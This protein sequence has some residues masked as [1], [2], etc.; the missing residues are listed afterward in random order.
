MRRSEPETN[1]PLPLIGITVVDLTHI[2]N[3]PYATF[4]MAMAGATVIK[5]EP[6]WGEHLRQRAE[7]ATA[8]VPFAMLNANKRAVTLDFTTERG[9]G[10]L[11]EMVRR[12]D[13]FVENFA[14]GVLDRH[15][16]GYRTLAQLFPT[17]IY[18]SSTGYGLSGP[19]RDYPAMDLTVQAMCGVLATTGDA[20]SGPTK[21]GPAV[22][23]FLA[24]V[25]LY[26]AIATALF[27]RERT[28]RGRL[29]EVSMQ[30][31]TY[32][33]LSSSIGLYF[34]DQ[35]HPLPRTGNHHSGLAEAPYGVYPARDG[36]IAIVGNHDRHFQ[37]IL[38]LMGRE[39]LTHD[40]RFHGLK[41]RAEHMDEVDDLVA[42]W[43]ATLD[44]AELAR[45]L[46]SQRVPCAPVREISEVVRDAHMHERG[47][48]EWIDHPSMGRIVVQRSPMRYQGSALTPLEP[49][50]TLGEHN[51]EVYADWLGF[52]DAELE[53]F[54]R[55]GII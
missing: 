5:V 26:G 20:E 47:A 33:S 27:E 7:L 42:D 14:P 36:Y 51:R 52:D 4:L 41:A 23:D 35:C 22:A 54:I 24:G 12:A 25:H 8:G 10:I 29:V 28:R 31:A 34:S 19:Y 46:L 55:D 49:S 45:L 37:A 21:A 15:Q 38:R 3:G 2:Y 13:V 44:K 43:T 18:A 48:L 1:R 9:R 30:E 11:L 53:G 32:A 6:R 39:D 50:P 17:L 40:R 16:L